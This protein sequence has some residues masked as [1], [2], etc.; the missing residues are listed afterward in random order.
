MAFVAG[1]PRLGGCFDSYSGFEVGL[2]QRCQQH[3]NRASSPVAAQSSRNFCHKSFQNSSS[4]SL[5]GELV[6]EG[7]SDSGPRP[8]PSVPESSFYRQ[9]EKREETSGTRPF[10]IEHLHSDSIFQD[11]DS[12]QGSSPYFPGDVGDVLGYNG[13]LSF[14]SDR[15]EVSKIFLFPPGWGC[16]HVPKAPFWIDNGS[17]GLFSSYETHKDLPSSK[18]GSS[19]LL[20]RRFFHRGHHKGSVHS[21]HSLDGKAADLVG[22]RCK[23]R[24]IFPHPSSITGI[25]RYSSEFEDPHSSSSR[26][27]GVPHPFPLS[28]VLP[29]HGDYSKGT[30]GFGGS[31]QFCPS[32]T[33]TRQNVASSS[34]FLDEHEHFSGDQRPSRPHRSGS[35]EGFKSLFKCRVFT[36]SDL[37]PSS[38]SIP[39]SG[40]GRLR[41]RLE[42]GDRADHCPRLLDAIGIIQFNQL[43]GDSSDPSFSCLPARL[44]FRQDH[45]N[46]HG[47][48]GSLVLF[49]ENG[50]SSFNLAKRYY[51]SFSFILHRQKYFVCACPHFRLSECSCRP[52]VKEGPNF[53]RMVPRSR[54]LR[55]DFPEVSYI[56]RGRPICYEGKFTV[57]S[58]CFSVPGSESFSCERSSSIFQLE[59]VPVHLRFSPSCSYGKNHRQDLSLQRNYGSDCSNGTI[60]PLVISPVRKSLLVGTSPSPVFSFSGSRSRDHNLGGRFLESVSVGSLPDQQKDLV[61]RDVEDGS[62]SCLSRGSRVSNPPCSSFSFE[63]FS[64]LQRRIFPSATEVDDED[65]FSEGDRDPN[66]LLSDSHTPQR[67]PFRQWCANLSSR[68]VTWIEGLCNLG[69]DR[70]IA[71]LIPNCHKESTKRQYQHA[72]QTWLSWCYHRGI[73]TEDVLTSTIINFLGRKFLDDDRALS[74]IKTYYYAIRDPVKYAYGLDI[75]NNDDIK[76]L[77]A[78]IWR[79]KP[80]VKGM[81]LMPKWSLE[82]LLNYLNSSPFEPLADA[83]N[84]HKLKKA[85][86]LLL[87][88][89]GRR[90]CEISGM[91]RYCLFLPNGIIKFHWYDGFTAKAESFWSEW[92]SS[93]PQIASISSNEVKLCPVRAFRAFYE[94]NQTPRWANGMWP[95]G[96]CRLSYLVRDTIKD[97]VRW[98]HPTAEDVPETKC[99]QFRK[100]ACS[101]SRK[102]FSGSLEELC[103]RVG[104]KSPRTLLSYYIREVPRVHCTFQV[105]AGTIFPDSKAINLLRDD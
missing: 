8:T 25:S 89:T 87:L 24:E 55:V 74:T 10:G 39:G 90:I 79:K 83:S 48:Y 88:A 9:K 37:L 68:E 12:R 45:Q 19:D 101:L 96:K 51:Q 73:R 56:P 5:R 21:S 82:D 35:G 102:Y 80:G 33:F 49:E 91:I 65:L 75:Y 30:R 22:V 41:L 64:P 86:I 81:R 78:A 2:L 58:L 62:S 26:R 100:L 104:T 16:L 3:P 15:Q 31:A 67:L 97:S 13:C 53:Y 1:S 59:P 7:Y 18:R 66:D 54:Y 43:A 105:P 84:E 95:L 29:F 32:S 27:Q 71:E 92:Q 94:S 57:S 69:I 17:M 70:D 6:E 28:G 98:A 50:F 11:G 4:S 76:K 42:R 77:F 14:H 40:Y 34:H 63:G 36:S 44:S 23:L 93:L 61:G 38:S 103:A 20:S 60:S 47:Q 72:W 99:H 52:G 85:V 46:P